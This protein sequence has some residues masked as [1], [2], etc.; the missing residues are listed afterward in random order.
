MPTQWIHHPW[1]APESVLQAAGV[2]LG[3]NYPL[4]IVELEDAK[5]RLQDALSEMWHLESAAR[6]AIENGLEEGLGD[7]S[8]L[9]NPDDDY[10]YPQELQMD[11]DL[12]PPLPMPR[13]A[14]P[15][16]AVRRRRGDQ[17]VPTVTRSLQRSDETDSS[18][19]TG[20]REVPTDTNFTVQPPRREEG[21]E[22]RT[23]R[24][25]PQTMPQSPS[26]WMERDNGGIVPVWSPTASRSSVQ[27][28]QL[29]VGRSDIYSTT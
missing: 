14:A 5:T 1:D 18:D 9:V 27:S 10:D 12:N 19:S 25:I 7:S 6:A 13:A 11:I 29:M 28:E 21:E 17:M 4:P 23:Q 24:E 3:S 15:T 20:R 22:A 26:N 2:E 16:N 8:E